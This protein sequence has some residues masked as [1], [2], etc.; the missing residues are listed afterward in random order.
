MAARISIAL[1]TAFVVTFCLFLGMYHLI[2]MGDSALTDGKH[3]RV[4][5]FVR[6]KRSSDLE[7][8]KRVLPQRVK[9][10]EQ[11]RQP[12]MEMPTAGASSGTAVN[13]APPDLDVGFKLQGG[14]NMGA[15]ASDRE[16]VPVVRIR[17][18]YPPRAAQRKIEGWVEL[19]FT[20]SA[21]GAVK[22][23]HVIRSKPPGVFD[24][25]A[26]R[27]VRKWKYKP[28]VENGVAIETSGVRVRLTFNLED[29]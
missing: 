10:E 26:L 15:V 29:Q 1:V 20:I 27:A 6:L 9:L 4:I 22:K 17:P 2:A 13:I 5:D 18:M 8:K 19:E 3:M 7:L 12:Q 14:L 23:P 24:K 25:A 16:I 28:R 21:T 11:P